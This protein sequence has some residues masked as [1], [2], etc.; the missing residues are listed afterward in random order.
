MS[1]IR[2]DMGGKLQPTVF[3]DSCKFAVKQDTSTLLL[4]IWLQQI[5][6]L[7]YT[8]HR[9]TVTTVSSFLRQE[10]NYMLLATQHLYQDT[11]QQDRARTWNNQS[12]IEQSPEALKHLWDSAQSY[13]SCAI[14]CRQQNIQLS[15][16]FIVLW[17]YWSHL[18]GIFYMFCENATHS[19]VRAKARRPESQGIANVFSSLLHA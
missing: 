19:T 17:I 10:S 9:Y 15:N 3:K 11:H 7:L 6:L 14:P 4:Y 18:S 1:D 13:V 16:Q 12:N 8:A 5:G 2:R